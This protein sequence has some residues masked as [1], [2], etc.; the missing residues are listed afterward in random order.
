MFG[1]RCVFILTDGEVKDRENVINLVELNS[2]SNT[3]FTI[4]F[5]RGCDAG[6]MERIAEISGGKSDF[7][8]EGDS[9]SEKLS[10]NSN[11]HFLKLSKA[12][13]FIVK[14]KTMIHLK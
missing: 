6:L 4:G 1:Q 7:I 10:H 3:C 13:K 2:K 14:E 8:Q 11:L 5:G 9:I 12:L